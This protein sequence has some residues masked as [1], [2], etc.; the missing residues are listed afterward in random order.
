M[1]PGG[2]EKNAGPPKLSATAYG[3]GS[4]I[5]WSAF[6]GLPPMVKFPAGE[7][8]FAADIRNKLMADRWVARVFLFLFLSSLK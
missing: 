3:S 5:T 2:L 1:H 7:G 6:G 8:R 4:P